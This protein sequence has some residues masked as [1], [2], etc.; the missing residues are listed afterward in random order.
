[1]VAFLANKQIAR[2]LVTSRQLDQTA[3]SA[4]AAP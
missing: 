4:A 3:D 1:M 2:D